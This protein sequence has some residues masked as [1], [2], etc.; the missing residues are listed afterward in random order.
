M[1]KE[2][3]RV[4]KSKNGLGVFAN[5]DIPKN[6][7][8][9]EIIGNIYKNLP[10]IIDENYLQ[11]GH[12]TFLGKTGGVDDYLNHSC[13]PNAFISAL[14]D[15]AILYSMYN[16]RANLEI[17][18]DYST[19]ST[20]TLDT[21]KMNCNCGSF[22]CRKIISGLQYVDSKIVEEYKNKGALPLF[23]YMKQFL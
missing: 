5:I 3:L 12:N 21:W 22:K 14:G 17:T 20:D 8:L 23:M 19:T 6:A 1:Y 2:Y 16:I 15:R 10:E 18:F 7:P 11:I 9:I 4:D 13:E